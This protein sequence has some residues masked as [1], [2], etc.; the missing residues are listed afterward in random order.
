MARKNHKQAHN[1]SSIHLEAEG[2]CIPLRGPF[3]PPE[4]TDQAWLTYKIYILRTMGYKTTPKK[5]EKAIDMAFDSGLLYTYWGEI[6]HLAASLM[7]ETFLQSLLTL[8]QNVESCSKDQV[9]A[10]M[11]ACDNP[12]PKNAEILINAGAKVDAR[13]YKGK[14]PLHYAAR[15]PYKEVAEALLSSGADVNARDNDGCTPLIVSAAFNSNAAVTE[16]LLEN[17]ADLNVKDNR[18]WNVLDHARL[19]NQNPLFQNILIGRG[20]SHTISQ[21]TLNLFSNLN[22]RFFY[23]PADADEAEQDILADTILQDYLDWEATQC[24]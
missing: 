8:K 2:P 7:D 6:L 1:S 21:K 18:G 5:C 11:V 3:S 13:D 20:L 9:T 15:N 14:T 23:V 12:N 10:L 16:L 24:K 17:G 22:S 4:P 19:I